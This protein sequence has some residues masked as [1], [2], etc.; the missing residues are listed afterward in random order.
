M[1][2]FSKQKLVIKPSTDI[3]LFINNSFLCSKSINSLSIKF[4]NSN[5]K[6]GTKQR[7]EI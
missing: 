4:Y 5:L 1:F 3:S 2:F 6:M 7:F